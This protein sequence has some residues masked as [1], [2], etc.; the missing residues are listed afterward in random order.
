MERMNFLISNEFLISNFITDQNGQIEIVSKCHQRIS[1][2]IARSKS[3]INM[4]VTVTNLTDLIEKEA[5]KKIVLN[6]HLNPS[7]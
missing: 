1:N 6:C 2:I 5:T 4:C 7:N 3:K